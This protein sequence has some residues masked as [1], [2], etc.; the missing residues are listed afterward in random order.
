MIV[1]P[2][3]LPRNPP[4]QASADVLSDVLRIVRLSG[5]VFF[6]ADLALPWAARSVSAKEL[7]QM[8]LPRAQQ[9]IPFHV[10]EHGRCWMAVD[11]SVPVELADGDV[12]VL[13]HCKEHTIASD[14]ALAPV[15]MKDIFPRPNGRVSTIAVGEGKARTRIVC[16]FL[17]CDEQLF[18]PL[19][20]GLPDIIHV[21]TT[22]EPPGSLLPALID[23][24]TREAQAD[25]DGTAC[26]LARVSELVFIEVLRR[27]I[28]SLGP[29]TIGWLGGLKDPLVGR[30]LRLLHGSPEHPWTVDDLSHQVGASRSLLA[31]RFRQFVGQPPMQYLTAWRLQLAASLLQNGA[32]SI[33]AIA[34]QVGYESE[35]AFNR[36][37]KRHTGVPPATW[38]DRNSA[39]DQA[40]GKAG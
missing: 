3:L 25:Q 20:H 35:P 32:P 24:M 1:A 33:S 9:M 27:H 34:L 6:R 40:L 14:I 12:I 2:D 7:K 38:R 4:L 5:A 13:P 19:C 29:D 37:F 18:N 36:A 39:R 31:D 17:H 16:G 26:L 30:A 11:G 23:S 15:P 22:A 21:R 10:V 28:A 8:L